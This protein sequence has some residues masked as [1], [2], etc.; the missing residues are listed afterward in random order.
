VL[1]CEVV[2]VDADEAGLLA[3]Q[4]ARLLPEHQHA[5]A[6]ASRPWVERRDRLAGPR[7]ESL[8]PGLEVAHVRL[9]EALPAL[10]DRARR[11][12]V[13]EEQTGLGG[14]LVADD[15]G[16]LI[17][18]VGGYLSAPFDRPS[19]ARRPGPDDRKLER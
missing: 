14:D 7:G 4:A 10:G 2:V 11:G 9:G 3:G 18:W 12:L 8:H 17:T 15:H 13:V 19:T 6:D 5:R 16:R 1:R